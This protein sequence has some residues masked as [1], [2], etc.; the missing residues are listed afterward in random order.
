[1]PLLVSST[2]ESDCIVNGVTDGSLSF[3]AAKPQWIYHTDSGNL[4]TLTAFDS[5]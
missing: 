3:H 5:L 4:H 1:M 2:K